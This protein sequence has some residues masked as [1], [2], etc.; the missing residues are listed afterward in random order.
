MRLPPQLLR[1]TT[2]VVALLAAGFV[3]GWLRFLPF[4]QG[5]EYTDGR[6][7][8]P[9]DEHGRLRFAVWEQPEPLPPDVNS[10]GTEG[11]AARSPDG[12][13]LVF[14]VGERGL[15]ADLWVAELYEGQPVDAHPLVALC[16]AADELAPA[17]GDGALWFASNRAGGQGG[18][19]LFRADYSDGSFG[20]PQRLQPGID[21]PADECDPAPLPDG[22]LAFSSNRLRGRRSDWDLYVALPVAGGAGRAGAVGAAGADTGA[23]SGSGADSGAGASSGAG[24]DP[25]THD[26]AAHDA[27]RVEAL[28]AL[29]TPFDEREPCAT[30]GGG[31]LLFASDRSGGRG[32]FDLW[33]S[34]LDGALWQPPEPLVGVNSP[35]DERAPLASA[36][37]FTLLFSAAP[38]GE[39]A[40]LYQARS[41]ELFRLPGRPVGWLDLTLLALLLVLALLTWLGRRWEALDILA[42]C[43]L[44]SLLVHVGLMLWFREVPV[45]PETLE[46]REGAPSFKVRIA[47]DERSLAA[48]RE[49]AGELELQRTGAAEAVAV[50]VREALVA[51]SASPEQFTAADRAAAAAPELK[52][53]EI[54]AAAPPER[55][56]ASVERSERTEAPL[57]AE[58]A[59][60]TPAER[61]AREAAP[62]PELVL[63][64]ATAAR[65][66][67]APAPPPV[68]PPARS[69]P[70]AAEAA[71]S[72]AA[73][74]ARPAA[75]PAST[76]L[77]L[78]M[79]VQDTPQAG[80]RV[81]D[82]AP[83]R[84]TV[85]DGGLPVALDGPAALPPASQR[86]G[87][88]VAAD[89]S[90]APSAAD[91]PA[92]T[93][94]ASDL[95]IAALAALPAA[96]PAR[97]R[98]SGAGA[99]LPPTR[100][101]SQA[102]AQPLDTSAAGAN[103]ASASPKG[104]NAA[105]DLVAAHAPAA[106]RSTQQAT[107]VTSLPQVAPRGVDA[108]LPAPRTSSTEGTALRELE[109]P[110][111][112]SSQVATG[113]GTTAA[114]AAA[115][116]AAAEGAT[117]SGAAGPGGAPAGASTSADAAAPLDL[118]ELLH[119]GSGATPSHATPGARPE[120]LAGAALPNRSQLGAASGG[121]QAPA[122][123]GERPG[124]EPLVLA[125]PA[126]ALPERDAERWEHTPYRSRFG[127]AKLKAIETYGGSQ[128]TERAVAEG[129]AYLARLQSPQGQWGS[130]DDYDDKYGHV[131][132]GKSALCLLAF[133]G[134]GHTPGSQT[135][136]SA[137][138]R[139]A[140]DFLL[141]VQD[142]ATGHFGYS[143]A[144]SHGITTYALAECYALTSEP[145]LR[146][147]L[148][149]AVA[150]ILQ[151]QLKTRDPRLFGGWTYYYPDGRSYDRWPRASISAW[152]V[153]ALES[154]RLGGLSVPDEAFADAGTF[155]RNTHRRD[156]GVM[157]YNHDPERL[158]SSYW[159]LPGSTPAA[160]FAL[161][162]LGEDVTDPL[163][164]S[165]VG[166]ISERAPREYR[167]RGTDAFVQ[168]AAGNL[169]FWYYGSLALLRHGGEAWTDWNRQ[170]QAT[171]LPA[172][173]RDGSWQ[174]IDTYAD[175]AGDDDLDR[176]YTTAMCVL[177][178]EVYYRYF[179]PL[180]AVQPI[181][182]EEH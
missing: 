177:T 84:A 39:P 160:L 28:T 144:Y 106:A 14:E 158:Q 18:L 176:S 8:R 16:S 86:T 6:S 124:F 141:S 161:S 162:L 166:Y 121:G 43:L 92:A 27:W 15:N 178:L 113:A 61:A 159:T 168:Q 23:N 123:G 118:G 51:S 77:G 48:S 82:L 57:H 99:A 91:S 179:T 53:P 120:R 78:P 156:R 146:A 174:P 133:L 155:L 110:A 107:P 102:L 81:V 31:A 115:T 154:A 42:K 101:S 59:V 45:E 134:A 40:D 54:P 136:H 89:N 165:V 21:T 4:I 19:D 111:A 116:G 10:H 76:R 135:E 180:L 173:E 34:V 100:A 63:P 62:A 182:A 157:L 60:A 33:R 88:T 96:T 170:L 126:P 122:R 72:L 128:Q 44:V 98:D 50:P 58:L 71:S 47:P 171:L 66:E 74:E 56:S 87:A 148:Q 147:P 68:A 94:D 64:D 67:P 73:A 172:Q 12:R 83:Q 70:R 163:Y 90:S 79:P 1:N 142:E 49:R 20:A 32:G 46:L 3:L 143:E 65:S 30:A 125:A 119:A 138:A 55:S 167:N 95:G 9:L 36:D 11:R 149:R 112:A 25:A 169:Y 80:R 93:S 38:P 41:R 152:Q 24:A 104:T 117:V 75:G 13:L 35:D 175:F 150:W 151:N 108:G 52:A 132:V 22:A 139:R 181:E 137:V 37:G 131:A 29:N 5:S 127:D 129:L 85:P 153:M 114:G 7:A 140:V 130:A 2:I 97:T 103:A 145:R 105:S 26:P 69:A 109:R 164:A 17:F